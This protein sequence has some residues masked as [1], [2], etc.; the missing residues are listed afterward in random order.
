MTIRDISAEE[1]SK[2]LSSGEALDIL[3]VRTGVECR[4][5]KLSCK[6]DYI[7]LHELDSK[8]FA[9]DRN[10]RGAAGPLYVLCRSGGRAAKAAAS[11]ADAG[12]ADIVIVKGGLSAC[13]SCNIPTE[14]GKVISLERQVRIAAGALVLSG[15]LLGHFVDDS[16]YIL[17]GLIGGGLI[18][19]GITDYCGMAMALARAPWNRADISEEINKSLKKFDE[20]KGSAS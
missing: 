3:D 19:A 18:F 6:V 13:S 5:E 10:A 2:K 12:V 15:V 9:A 8:R 20:M 1:F 7:P 17:S 4:A 11:L 16:F 14:K